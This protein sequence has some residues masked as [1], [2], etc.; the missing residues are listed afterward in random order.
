MILT[1]VNQGGI[2]VKPSEQGF[3]TGD[4][5]GIK[6]T[7]MDGEVS[8]QGV[9]TVPHD[10]GF[11]TPEVEFQV[12]MLGFGILYELSKQPHKQVRSVELIHWPSFDT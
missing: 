5:L 9:Y 12:E 3:I 8:Y 2:E 7:Y 10:S 6:F 1:Q 11:G 4:K